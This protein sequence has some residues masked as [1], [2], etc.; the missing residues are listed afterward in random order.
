MY[1]RRTLGGPPYPGPRPLNP[2]FSLILTPMP[3]V[4][5][6]GR[7]LTIWESPHPGLPIDHRKFRLI[8][9]SKILI[10]RVR[11]YIYMLNNSKIS[12]CRHIGV[13]MKF[14]NLGATISYKHSQ[15]LL[16][17]FS[18]SGRFSGKLFMPKNIQTKFYT[19]GESKFRLV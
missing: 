15:T 7:A 14:F 5:P 3:R 12:P 4:R 13:N 19:G 9:V 6:Q 16:L 1:R 18:N 11:I 8:I 17:N 10:S 2:V